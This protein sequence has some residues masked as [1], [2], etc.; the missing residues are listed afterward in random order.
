MKETKRRDGLGD[1]LAR[2]DAEVTPTVVV[3][4]GDAHEA[5]LRAVAASLASQMAGIGIE[6][7]FANG[8]KAGFESG[9]QAG[10]QGGFEAGRLVSRREVG[11]EL[12]ETGTRL[13]MEDPAPVK[14]RRPA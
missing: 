6:T 14:I 5:D 8:F 9:I 11:A 4:L 7:G 2:R 1:T 13:I 10:I 3:T 12:M